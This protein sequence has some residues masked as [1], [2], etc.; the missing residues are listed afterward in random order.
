MLNN[1]RSKQEVD[2]ENFWGKIGCVTLILAA[3][4]YHIQIE[5]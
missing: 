2:E 3:E 4:V 5:V 1:S